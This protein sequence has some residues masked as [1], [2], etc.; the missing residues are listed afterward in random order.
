ML[1]TTVNQTIK[2]SPY[3]IKNTDDVFLQII[4]GK[5]APQIPSL[6][7]K[8]SKIKSNKRKNLPT[9]RKTSPKVSTKVKYL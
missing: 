9:I 7:I 5:P 8:G 4:E 1:K 2:P 3:L 6:T